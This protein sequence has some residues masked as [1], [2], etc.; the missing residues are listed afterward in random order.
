MVRWLVSMWHIW[1]SISSPCVQETRQRVQ[2]AQES[3]AD[4]RWYHFDPNDSTACTSPTVSV[5]VILLWEAAAASKS[6]TVHKMFK[7]ET[8]AL[9]HETKERLKAS[10][11][12]IRPRQGVGTPRDWGTE[13]EATSLPMAMGGDCWTPKAVRNTESYLNIPKLTES[14][15]IFSDD[16]YQ[17]LTKVGKMLTP[18]VNRTDSHW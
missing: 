6:R 2:W 9:T 16:K 14:K 4:R 8:E 13:T 11:P 17:N 18:D 5:T 12:K 1:L 15:S 7:P 3:Q 10:K